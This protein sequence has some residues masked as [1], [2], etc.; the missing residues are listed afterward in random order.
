M[1]KNTLSRREFMRLAGLVAAGATVSACASVYDKVAGD[2][3]PL[4]D[5]PSAT[6]GDFRILSRL[7][8]GPRA[9]ERQRVAEIGAQAWIDEQ[10]AYEALDD[11]AVNW[12]LQN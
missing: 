3:K 9:E 7:T 12:R 10:L 8:F 6:G 4:A 5:W 1:S 2:P 11:Q